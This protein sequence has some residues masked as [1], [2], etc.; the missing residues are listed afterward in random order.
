MIQSTR[1]DL[2][3]LAAAGAATAA[4][5][6]PAAKAAGGPRDSL[7]ALAKAKGLMGFGSCIGDTSSTSVSGSFQ[8]EG[9]RAIHVRECGILVPSNDL[10]WTVLRPN[11]QDFTFYRGDRIVDWAEA[12]RMKVRGHNLLWLRPDRNPDWIA[13][14]DFGPRP[15]T[16]AERLLREH[17]TTV[18]KRYG[19]RIFTWDVVNEAIDP[20]TGELRE[21]AFTKHLGAAVM[22]IAFD[23]AHRAVPNCT[24]VYNDYMGWTDTSARH[25]DGVLKLLSRMKSAGLPVHVLGV[26][27]HIG[28]GLIGNVQGNMDFNAREQE[29]FKSFL[30]E[31]VRMGHRLA[32]TEFDIS[33]DGTPADIHARDRIMADLTRRYMDFMLRY[34]ELDYVM[35][36]GMV[37]HHSWLQTRGPRPDGML[38]RPSPYDP[39]YEPKPMREA[40]ADAFRAMNRRA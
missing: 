26:Q 20:A 15:A 7:D 16:E 23:A 32:I 34:R 5:P 33:E 4:L 10:K 30:D 2:M 21:M 8:D 11:P 38:K 28:A 13:G 31:A 1:R 37:D 29:Q 9:V 19:D 25:R 24:L 3:G 14:Y 40:F 36:W 27:A 39:N 22:D 35:T 6:A 12:N 17:I 18:C